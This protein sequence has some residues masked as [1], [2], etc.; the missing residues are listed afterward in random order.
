MSL[1]A[2]ARARPWQS[3]KMRSQ[4]LSR[5]GPDGGWQPAKYS[6][7]LLEFAGPLLALCTVPRQGEDVRKVMQLASFCW[8]APVYQARGNSEL[9]QA[10][11][12]VMAASPAEVREGLRYMID[13]RQ[14]LL[15]RCRSPWSLR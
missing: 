12:A 5:T 10:L 8:N 11:Q 6:D 2:C 15:A 7:M 3:A 9:T 14:E 13:Q 4:L 1:R